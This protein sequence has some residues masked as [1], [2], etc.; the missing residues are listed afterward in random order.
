V[1]DENVCSIGKCYAV[2]PGQSSCPRG[3]ISFRMWRVQR[4][5]RMNGNEPANPFILG[6]VR[7]KSRRNGLAN[8]FMLATIYRSGHSLG[9]GVPCPSDVGLAHADFRGLS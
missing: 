9:T 2:Y 5:D 7:W 8:S 3:V 1:S 4:L 6:R